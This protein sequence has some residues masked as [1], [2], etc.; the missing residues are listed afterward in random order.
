MSYTLDDAHE[1]LALAEW[2]LFRIDARIAIGLGVARMLVPARFA[3]RGALADIEA[4]LP[5]PCEHC[6]SD[7]C[8]KVDLSS[9]GG[10]S[11]RRIRAACQ[12]PKLAISLDVRPWR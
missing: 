10:G 8:R 4:D 3:I 1:V 9:M 11:E 6:G 12:M 5:E 7:Q 2:Y